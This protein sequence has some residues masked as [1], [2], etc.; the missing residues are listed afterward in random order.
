ME[1]RT[2]SWGSLLV[3]LCHIVQPVGKWGDN[4][5]VNSICYLF[6]LRNIYLHWDYCGMNVHILHLEM[7]KAAE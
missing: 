5:V 7:G 4:L 1:S 6:H 2:F 3:G